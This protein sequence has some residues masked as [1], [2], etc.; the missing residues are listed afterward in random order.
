[1]AHKGLFSFKRAFPSPHSACTKERR[2]HCRDSGAHF[3]K[4]SFTETKLTLPETNIAP[5]NGWLEYCTSFLL[6]YVA[7]LQGPC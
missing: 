6:G 5:A 1:M 3:F 7:Y 2:P 4:G